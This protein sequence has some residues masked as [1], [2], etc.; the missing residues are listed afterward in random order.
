M[1]ISIETSSPNPRE[2]LL[3]ALLDAPRDAV[4]RAWT[5]PSLIVQWFT[6][7]PWKRLVSD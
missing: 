1:P 6:P 4:W 3:D 5:D 7:A 2:L